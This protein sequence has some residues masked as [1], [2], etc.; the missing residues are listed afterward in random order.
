MNTYILLKWI[1]AGCATV[2]GAGF[3]CRY[4]LMLA[5]SPLAGSRM[6]RV[7]PHV[8]DTVLLVS[9]VALAWTAGAMPLRDD[10]LTT[11]IGGLVIYI[12]L[13]SLALKRARTKRARALAGA[14][15]LAVFGHIASVALT[16]SP[17]GLLAR[18]IT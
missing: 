2:S 7:A 9:A 15:A 12:G 18:A 10:W 16:K 14:L 4:L 3:L 8:V 17:L 11:K 6:A 1:H 13:G 5:N